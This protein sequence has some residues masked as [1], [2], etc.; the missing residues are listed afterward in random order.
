[1]L[2]FKHS[3]DLGDIIYSLPVIRALG[4]GVLMLDPEGG[5]TEPLC[6][7]GPRN[8]HHL[9]AAR[10]D[11]LKPLLSKQPY[12][13]DVVYWRGEKVDHNL[14]EFRRHLAGCENLVDA[15]LFA[16]GLDSSERQRPWLDVP[17][18][19]TIPGRSIVL[20][21]SVRN[22]GN[23]SFW[24]ANMPQLAP[25]AVFVGLPKEHDIFQYS[26]EIEVPY[27]PTTD[28]LELARVVAGASQF[29]GNASFPHA[30]AQAMHHRKVILEVNRMGG[31][32]CNVVFNRPG[33]QFV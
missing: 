4:G 22:L 25:R 7:S 1:V 13:H 10:I 3:G 8:G 9:D 28:F 6:G 16:F 5:K 27:R 18:A 30:L 15:H 33:V 24:Y 14:D 23:F 26:F 12:I 21:R 17:D 19:I 29:I 11:L 31:V 32:G 2:T 20:H